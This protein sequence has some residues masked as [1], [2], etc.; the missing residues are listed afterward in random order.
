M[1]YTV[2]PDSFQAVEQAWLD[3]LPES[4]TN[5]VFVTPCWQEHWFKHFGG[6]R[7]M[8]LLSVR[9]GSGRL[10]GIA[11]LLLNGSKLSLVGNTEVCDYSDV[12]LSRDHSEGG[13]SAILDFLSPLRWERLILHS[14]PSDSPTLAFLPEMARARG[15]SVQVTQEDVCPRVDLPDQWEAY[16]GRLTK[17]DRHELR[18]KFR[19]LQTAVEVRFVRNG[20]GDDLSR[21]M[22]DF[23]RLH[24]LSRE[25]KAEFMTPPMED[26]FRQTIG[27]LASRGTAGISF[28]DLDGVRAAAIIYFDYDGQR[29]LYNSGYDPAFSALSVG[30]LLKAQ[31]LRD[32]IEAG[33]KRFDFL[34]GNEPYKYDLGGLDFPIYQ[35][36]VTRV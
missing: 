7:Q 33:M 21:E 16:L 25:D 32:A 36:V 30:L 10:V 6:E 35:C 1:S 8:E 24:R 18:R 26:F 14:L 9:E 29:L 5:T 20:A 12:V 19:R 23:F 13:L 34:R 31:S 17:K 4:A 2:A 11:P 15:W 27:D 3:L 22:D 28:L